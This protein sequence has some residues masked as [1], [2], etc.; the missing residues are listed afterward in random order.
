MQMQIP[1]FHLYNQVIQNFSAISLSE[2][3]P[4]PL[5][6]V[7]TDSPFIQRSLLPTMRKQDTLFLFLW[8]VS[9]SYSPEGL[10]VARIAALDKHSVFP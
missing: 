6:Y 3:M 2:F 10:S 4:H 8:P 5:T 9:I 7:S 1:G